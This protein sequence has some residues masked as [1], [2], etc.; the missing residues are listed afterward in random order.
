MNVNNPTP[1]NA[2]PWAIYAR[3]VVAWRHRVAEW[4][5]KLVV[6]PRSYVA[7]LARNKIKRDNCAP[8]EGWADDL[9]EDVERVHAQ[10]LAL[11]R[12]GQCRLALALEILGEDGS[13]RATALIRELYQAGWLPKPPESPRAK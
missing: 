9:T 12:P 10:L 5:I 11:A 3:E 1:A 13:P 7:D 4:L 6:Y 8:P 2:T